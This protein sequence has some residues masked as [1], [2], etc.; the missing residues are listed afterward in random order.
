M[1][2]LLLRGVAS[3]GCEPWLANR[4]SWPIDPRDWGRLDQ[5]VG[6]HGIGFAA[7]VGHLHGYETVRT[8]HATS[9]WYERNFPFQ[10]RGVDLIFAD[11]PRWK[12][13]RRLWRYYNTREEVDITSQLTRFAER[14][15][16][17]LCHAPTNTPRAQGELTRMRRERGY[18][19]NAAVSNVYGSHIE[20][21]IRLLSGEDVTRGL[22]S[23]AY[24]IHPVDADGCLKGL[25]GTKP[26]ETLFKRG[27]AGCRLGILPLKE[28][29]DAGP[30]LASSARIDF[31]PGFYLLG[32]RARFKTV[33][34]VTAT[35]V[36]QLLLDNLPQLLMLQLCAAA[37]VPYDGEIPSFPPVR[38][39]SLTARNSLFTEP[40]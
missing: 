1:V 39:S 32:E 28:E 38:S 14:W 3:T 31:P 37:R 22:G 30:V 18:L 26:F 4:S 33:Q 8:L 15:G 40:A 9:M 23:R 19:P 21:N 12:R 24:V 25:Q 27:A 13:D 36:Q 29:Y 20:E 16:I 35:F 2:R 7:C 10:W 34:T 5:I 11:S 6:S 17:R